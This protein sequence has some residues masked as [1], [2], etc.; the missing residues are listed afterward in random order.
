MSASAPPGAF[1]S[2]P[3]RWAARCSAAAAFLVPALALSAPSGYSWGAVLILCAAA[4]SVRAWLGQRVQASTVL[5]ALCMVALA[6]VWGVE[7][8]LAAGWST[9]D[10]PS[11]FL[12]AIPCL[13][14]LAW[15]RPPA[16]WIAAGVLAGAVGAGVTALAQWHGCHAGLQVGGLY[17]AERCWIVVS[18]TDAR[19]S[20]YTNAI[21]FGNI[22]LLLGLMSL[23]ALAVRW[24]RWTLGWR[25]AWIAAAV[26]A[27]EA[28]LLSMARGGWL[29]LALVLPYL[30]YAA[31]RWASRRALLLW[32]LGLVLGVVALGLF[33]GE[34]LGQRAAIAWR[35]AQQFQQQGQT[36]TSV[37][38]RLAHWSL[39]WDMAQQRPWTGWTQAGYEEEKARRVAT[40]LAPPVVL[41]FGHAHNEVLDM[42]AKRGVVGLS[43]L[44]ALYLVPLWIFWPTRQRVRGST[45]GEDTDRTRLGLHVAGTL[46][47]LTYIGFGLTQVFFAHNS[48][49]MFYLFMVM[50]VHAALLGH[51]GAHRAAS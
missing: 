4:L 51:A 13:M 1:A 8:N 5:L 7:A 19:V 48:G 10:R 45:M 2:G 17:S 12:L 26:L 43:A 42:L 28:S 31:W 49:V 23:V 41:R 20:G 44:L 16:R 21:Q 29:A 47:P 6:A 30:A 3:P 34:E 40:G 38:H 32:G 33:K 25:W 37:G 39:A 11:K 9:L 35:E 18:P 50:L 24:S 27:L 14:F 15:C 36:E 46:L 22:A